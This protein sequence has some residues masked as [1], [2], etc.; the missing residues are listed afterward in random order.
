MKTLASIWKQKVTSVT[1]ITLCP[2][3]NR[4]VAAGVFFELMGELVVVWETR[5]PMRILMLIPSLNSL[6]FIP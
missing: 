4:F 5:L 1:M 6:L 2:N 3:T